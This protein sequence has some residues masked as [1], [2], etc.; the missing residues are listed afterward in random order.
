MRTLW[1]GTICLVVALLASAG[2]AN[3]L[4]VAAKGRTLLKPAQMSPDSVVLDVFFVRFPFGDAEANETLW[5]EVD[6]QQIPAEV[7]KRLAQNGF[8]AG[9]VGNQLPVAL[10]KLLE[11]KDKPAPNG[12][13]TQVDLNDLACEPRVDRRHMS[14]R[15]RIP[16]Q[17]I[18]TE[19]HGELTVLMPEADGLCG[20]T[21]VQAQ[22]MFAVTAV[23]QPDGRVR[24]DLLPELHHDQPKQRWIGDQGTLRLDM[25][26]PKRAFDTLGLSA[27]LSPGNMLLMTSLP[28]RP[29]SLGHQFFTCNKE[30]QQEQ[31]LLVIRLAQTQH[32]ELYSPPQELRLE[33]K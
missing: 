5:Q 20:Q 13:A 22:G 6:E 10:S 15:T 24:L 25:A 19:T 12:G 7:R 30:G 3:P 16:G 33:E 27:T 4:Q 14:V 17:I 31:K 9:T 23:P 11:L 28:N 8:R 32:N 1:A 26:R 2:C 29:G 21:Y 18:A